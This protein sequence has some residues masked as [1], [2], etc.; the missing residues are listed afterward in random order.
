VPGALTVVGPPQLVI[1]QNL[2]FWLKA[3][4]FSQNAYSSARRRYRSCVGPSFF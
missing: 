4:E 2:T 3:M 1:A